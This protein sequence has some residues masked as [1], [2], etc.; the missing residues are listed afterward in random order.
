[1]R[2]AWGQGEKRVDGQERLVM[3]VGFLVSDDGAL[4]KPVMMAVHL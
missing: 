4:N 2:F 1:M 3:D